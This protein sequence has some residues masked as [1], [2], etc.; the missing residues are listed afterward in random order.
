[1]TIFLVF[2]CS[3][4]EKINEERILKI[5]HDILN[6][7]PQKGPSYDHSEIRIRNG[8]NNKLIELTDSL[9]TYELNI[10]KGDFSGP[11]GD[12][13]ADCILEIHT[14]YQDIGIRLKYE[15]KYD[16]YDVLGYMTLVDS[17]IN[18]K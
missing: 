16:K 15:K 5:G 7:P 18:K 3:H 14:D 10:K 13:K 9:N 6:N 1:M 17:N 11:Y 2:P 12:N 4:F 8:L